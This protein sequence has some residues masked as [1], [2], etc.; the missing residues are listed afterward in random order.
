[1]TAHEHDI[2]AVIAT[3]RTDCM[4]TGQRL[5]EK[6]ENILR[7]LLATPQPISAY[8]IV[9]HYRNDY[10]D[11]LPAMSVYR[12]LQFLVDNKLAHKLA[13]TNQFLACSHIACDHEHSVPQFLICDECHRVQEVSLRKELVEELRNS[14]R[15]TGFRLASQQLELHG[16][17]DRCE[18]AK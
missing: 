1:M 9:E 6:R 12:M 10:G 11:S 17:C 18:P 3:A 2:D 15:K 14:V 8:D 7:I 5:T 4:T 13:T 16:T